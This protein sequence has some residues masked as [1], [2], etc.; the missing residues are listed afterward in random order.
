MKSTFRHSR[1][2]V[3]SA[4]SGSSSFPYTLIALLRDSAARI[5][6]QCRQSWRS[7]TNRRRSTP[8]PLGAISRR[9]AS[10]QPLSRRIPRPDRSIQP[11]PKRRTFFPA[12]TFDLITARNDVNSPSP[13]LSLFAD[14]DTVRAVPWQKRLISDL[15]PLR[16]FLSEGAETIFEGE[17]R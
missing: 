13:F 8:A 15:P 12:R 11:S 10:N 17:P 5:V 2:F 16:H 3:P 9:L 7:S 14:V 4:K 1:V 6:K